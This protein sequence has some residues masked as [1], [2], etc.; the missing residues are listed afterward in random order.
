MSHIGQEAGQAFTHLTESSGVRPIISHILQM[1]KLGLGDSAQAGCL[2]SHGV[3]ITAQDSLTGLHMVLSAVPGSQDWLEMAGL[4]KRLVL[5]SETICRLESFR[6]EPKGSSFWLDCGHM[7]PLGV[8]KIY[9]VAA[10]RSQTQQP[11]PW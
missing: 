2:S 9:R 4:E 10:H 1:A 3:S 8:L 7:P 5:R 6:N 11:R